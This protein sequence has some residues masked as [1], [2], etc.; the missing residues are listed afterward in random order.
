MS[1]TS[2]IRPRTAFLLLLV[3]LAFAVRAVPLEAQSLWR[4]EV[5]ALCYAFGFPQALLRAVDP[6]YVPSAFPPCACP[7]TPVAS[8]RPDQPLSGRLV[9]V[10][11]GMI[12]NNGPLYYFLLR[13]WIAL[14]G[15][16]VSALRFFSLWFGV[17]AV[18]LVYVLGTRLVRRETGT[19]AAMLIALSPYLVWYSQEVKMYSL[20]TALALLAVYALRRAVEEGR[21]RWWATVVA[22][23]TMAF[24]LH[25]WCA[26]LVPLYVFLLLLWRPR[27]RRRWLGA[28]V[29]LALL[30]LPYIPLAA[31]EIRYALVP[32]ETGFPHHTLG[33]MAG[34]LWTGWTTGI[35]AWG[36]L[37][38]TLP[39]GLAAL[40]GVTALLVGRRGRARGG[41][42][43][44]GLLGWMAVPLLG[45]WA[46]S[47]RQ[48][49]FTDRYLIWAAPA[50]YLLCG[51][52]IDFLWR[53][54]RGAAFP[55]ALAVLLVF[56]GN[57][58]VQSALPTKADLRAAAAFVEERY[59]AGDLLIFQIPHI[60]YTF[61]YYFGPPTYGW[62]DGLYTNYRTPEGT[63]QMS[64]AQAAQWMRSMTSGRERVWFIGSEVAM[65]DE[66]NLVWRWLEAHG[67]RIEEGHFLWVD[68]YLYRLN[69][70]DA[71]SAENS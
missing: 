52:G 17:L 13:G 7:P 9:G 37:L 56:G 64:E 51:A 20:V 49:L 12:R 45:I 53:W 36:G 8:V 19:A 46:V 1:R 43:L 31:W 4:D 35:R 23:T 28:V 5:D 61:D 34:I 55:L 42:V 54:G 69:H 32:R 29:T 65:W 2:A 18:P 70:G 24:Y 25:I 16:S 11:R 66:R 26:L 40:L 62:A 48:P 57:L 44:L 38:G 63:Y 27:G 59:E 68:V 60:R 58:W 71:E 30:T 33:Q 21:A 3:L 47:L 22:A 67:D 15:T 6:S 10:L 14:G 50:L 41:Q 39:G